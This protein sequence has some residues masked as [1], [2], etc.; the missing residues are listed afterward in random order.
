MKV[1]RWAFRIIIG[2]F[3]LSLIGL[4][5]VLAL[6]YRAEPLALQVLDQPHTQRVGSLIVMEPDE[7]VMNLVFYQGG[8]VQTEAYLVFLEGLREAG[9]RV[10]IPRMPLNLAILNRHA[11]EAIYRDYPSD[12]PW[13]AMGHSLGGATLSFVAD[14][15]LEALILIAS[16]P[17]S[18][19]DLS[20]GPFKVL[21]ITASN[22][23]ILNWD[24]FQETRVL[25]PDDTVFIEIEGGNHA[26]FA[27]YGAQRGDGDPTISKETQMT[28]TIEHILRF[29]EID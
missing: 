11:I 22:D 7:A 10:F 23:E 13:V 4:A 19:E 1:L 5:M 15:R 16:Y 20:E 9:V 12:L 3:I 6:T 2:F 25:L 24:Q 14:A 18:S 29:L 26:N 28:Q 27:H 17:A 21:S 8:L